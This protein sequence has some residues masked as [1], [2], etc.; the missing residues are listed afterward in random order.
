MLETK[1]S[2]HVHYSVDCDGTRLSTSSLFSYIPRLAVLHNVSCF[3]YTTLGHVKE[4]E[5]IFALWVINV[6]VALW[7]AIVL[8]VY[9]YRL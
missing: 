9:I 3:L 2:L 1:P 4:T 5:S 8:A 6:H 7:I